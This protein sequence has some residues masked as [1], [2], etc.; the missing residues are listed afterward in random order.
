[1]E[2]NVRVD[3]LLALAASVKR[4]AHLPGVRR[5]PHTEMLAIGWEGQCG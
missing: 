5:P 4:N 2:A 3:G 1:M